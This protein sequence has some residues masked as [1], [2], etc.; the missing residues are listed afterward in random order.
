MKRGLIGKTLVHSF[1]KEIHELISSKSNYDLYSLSESELKSF[2]E[3]KDFDYVNVTIPY[4]EKTL[5]YVDVLSDEV[6]KIKALNLIVNRNNVLYGYNTDYLAF[7][8]I[9]DDYNISCKGKNVL[10]LGTGGTSKTVRNV[11]EKKMVNK[12]YIASRKESSEYISYSDIYNLDVDIIVNTTPVGMFPNMDDELI[13]LN[14][15]KKV[16]WV[17]DFIYNPL[18]TNLLIDAQKL[19]INCLNGLDILIYQALFAF[20]IASSEKINFETLFSKIKKEILKK[21]NIVL[22][23]M[24]FSGKTTIGKWLKNYFTSKEFYDVD[25]I[26]EEKYGSISKIFSDKGEEEFRKLEEEVTLELSTKQNAIIATG[27]GTILS[28]KNV[29]RLKHLGVLIFLDR[30]VD[31]LRVSDGRPLARNKSDLES[32]YQKRYDKYLEASDLVIKENNL[33]KCYQEC[34]KIITNIK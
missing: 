32:L 14:K 7:K 6:K 17:I 19:N 18:R 2:L 12:I 11:F 25:E 29:R 4:K 1:S 20:G 8:K 15:F 30:D 22:I 5:E 21:N 10:V 24:P 16:N 3:K 33:D 23:G 26:I 34:V 31:F 9:L 27:G 13:D 28:E